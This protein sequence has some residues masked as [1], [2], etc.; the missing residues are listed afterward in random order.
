MTVPREVPTG[1]GFPPPPGSFA[2]LS[3][4]VTGVDI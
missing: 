2:V 3:S 4:D 1:A